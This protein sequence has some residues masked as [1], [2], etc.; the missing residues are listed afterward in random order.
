MPRFALVLALLGYFALFVF[1]SF[2]QWRR[3]GSTGI[4]GFHGAIGS[5]P[6]IAGVLVGMGFLLAPLAPA[7]A[8]LGWPGGSIHFA[9]AGLH[10]AGAGL[11]LIGIAGGL[12]AQ[13]TMG[14]SWRIGVDEADR[15]A[16]VTGGLFAR[17]RN[18][19]FSF[20]GLSMLGLLSMVPNGFALAACVITF[21]GIELQVR[22]V[23][24][25]Y[26]MRTHG[27]AYARYVARVG[28]FAPG[29]G[30]RAAH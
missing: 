25:P 10:V 15:T 18:P 21:A 1:R 6:W 12:V 9:S 19:I 29:I 14:D 16:L 7:A 13:L 2:V 28:R 23:E 17:V 8:L 4:K 20:M 27:D 26:L 30:R 3:T 5:T 24:E 22:A 11:M